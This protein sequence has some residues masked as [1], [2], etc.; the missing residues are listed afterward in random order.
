MCT[1]QTGILGFRAV[2]SYV[3]ARLYVNADFDTKRKSPLL[4]KCAEKGLKQRA[5]EARQVDCVV[6]GSSYSVSDL[7]V[8]VNLAMANIPCITIPRRKIKKCWQN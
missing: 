5:S 2:T 1:R 4:H 6:P 3:A 7:K 8:D